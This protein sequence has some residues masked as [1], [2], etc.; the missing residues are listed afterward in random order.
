MKVLLIN[1]QFADGLSR[2]MR[3]YEY[4][5]QLY[6]D[7]LDLLPPGFASEPRRK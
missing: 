4:V 5:R 7:S 2:F 3:I 1:L 6:H